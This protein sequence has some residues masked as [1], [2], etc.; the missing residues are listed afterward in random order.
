MQ[1]EIETPLKEKKEEEH[2]LKTY[3][4][5]PGELFGRLVELRAGYAKVI[6]TTNE[7]MRADSK[8]LLNA[9]V[10]FS[11]ALL[12][13][14]ASVNDPNAAPLSSEV[15][16]L[17]PAKVGDVLYFEAYEKYQKG[18]RREIEVIGML[19]DMKI[20]TATFI[21]LVFEEHILKSKLPKYK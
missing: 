10:I 1:E 12:A 15:E 8:D 13:A 21:A 5:V 9:G 7:E 11:A 20:F 6:L 14:M 18:K 4:K 16:F 3:D 17:A 2:F 19:N